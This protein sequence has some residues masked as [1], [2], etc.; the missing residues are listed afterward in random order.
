M[1]ASHDA[2]STTRSDQRAEPVVAAELRGPL[3][4]LLPHVYHQLRDLARRQRRR[5][6][7]DETLD[8]TAL[9]HEAYLRLAD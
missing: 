2:R 1:A 5:W 8:T 6:D 7:G 4:E 3:D 9:V